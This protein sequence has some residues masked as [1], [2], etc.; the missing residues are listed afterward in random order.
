MDSHMH[1]DRFPEQE[2]GNILERA[3]SVGIRVLI[4]VGTSFDAADKLRAL[5]D[6]NAGKIYHSIGAHPTE[7]DNAA[8]TEEEVV[9]VVKRT[10][11]VAI[12]ET[13]F[14][15]FSAPKGLGAAR[16]MSDMQRKAFLAQARVAKELGLPLIIH[17]RESEP[18][19]RDAWNVLLWALKRMQFPMERALLHCFDYGPEEIV[20]WQGEGAFASFSGSVTRKDRE[21]SQKALQCTKM[22]QILFET[23][24][25]FLLPEPLR[26]TS[27][28]TV[29]EPSHMLYTMSLAAKLW[30]VEQEDV[31]E[32][33]LKNGLR[34]FGLDR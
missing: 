8:P 9:D 3:R 28:K 12:G 24:A 7:L 13:G 30:G 27:P 20:R 18:S 31:L 32:M 1:L 16:A 22:D 33:S 5:A 21:A 29:C 34:F 26:T 14:D 19:K 17:C 10:R 23:D 4:T 2:R 11:P 6:E 15:Y 25:P